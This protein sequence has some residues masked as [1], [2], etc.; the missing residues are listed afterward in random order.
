MHV[1]GNC[2]STA[3]VVEQLTIN[4][5]KNDYDIHITIDLKLYLF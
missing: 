5:M 2:M 4:K 1:H 3:N